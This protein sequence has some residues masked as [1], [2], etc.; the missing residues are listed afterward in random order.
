[1]P[2]STEWWVWTVLLLAVAGFA[3]W[4]GV[5]WIK[6]GRYPV[7]V[8]MFFVALFCVFETVM[9]FVDTGRGPGGSGGAWTS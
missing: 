4:R 2:V 7:A 3:V 5:R 1:M 6:Q 9:R 8:A